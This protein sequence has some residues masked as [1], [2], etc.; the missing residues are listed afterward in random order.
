MLPLTDFQEN[1]VRLTEATKSVM[2]KEVDY[3]VIPGTGKNAKPTLLKAGAEKLKVLYGLSTKTIIDYT[4]SYNNLAEETDPAKHFIRYVV[5]CEVYKNDL[6]LADQTAVCHSKEKKYRERSKWENGQ[7]IKVANLDIA[8]LDNTILKMAE[9]RAFVG[10]MLQATGASEFF[11]QDMED[12]A[13]YSKVDHQEPEIKQEIKYVNKNKFIGKL[14]QCNT[15]QEV[16]D[17]VRK[18]QNKIAPEDAEEILQA[19]KVSGQKILEN[20][21]PETQ[22]TSADKTAK[23]SVENTEKQKL[24]K[25]N[26]KKEKTADIFAH[27]AEFMEMTEEEKVNKYEGIKT[28]IIQSHQNNEIDDKEHN[29]LLVNIANALVGDT[30]EE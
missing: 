24:S 25:K 16:K 21:M 29:T 14:S 17:L 13:D 19:A 6:L 20:N 26:S 4:Q 5:K 1:Y 22:E 23:E 3:G 7:Q 30:N 15:T 27:V 18:Y 12:F 11:T 10:A 28:M 9:K 8:D 2:R